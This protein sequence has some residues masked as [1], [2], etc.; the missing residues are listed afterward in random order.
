MNG[1]TKNAFV[2]AKWN[3]FVPQGQDGMEMN[4]NV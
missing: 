4:V 1:T 3:Q 2:N